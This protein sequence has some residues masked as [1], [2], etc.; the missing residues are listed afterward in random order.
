MSCGKFANSATIICEVACA[1]KVGHGLP[2]GS[3]RLFRE[4]LPAMKTDGI[5]LRDLFDRPFAQAGRRRLK[6]QFLPHEFLGFTEV[7][8]AL[9]VGVE[10]SRALDAQVVDCRVE[11][12]SENSYPQQFPP[13]RE[14]PK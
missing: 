9:A 8:R 12:S 5:P 4:R 3:I 7:A 1:V 13:L 14:L 2:D 11:I 10:Y 6:L